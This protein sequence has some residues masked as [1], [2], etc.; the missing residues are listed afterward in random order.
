MQAN[1]LADTATAMRRTATREVWLPRTTSPPAHNAPAWRSLKPRLRW[2]PMYPPRQAMSA[3]NENTLLF[4]SPAKSNHLP[5]CPRL[6]WGWLGVHCA[7]PRSAGVGPAGASPLQHLTGCGCLSA[8]P[9]GREASSAARPHGLSRRRAAPKA[10]NTPL[11][12]SD[13]RERGGTVLAGNPATGGASTRPTTRPTPTSGS[14]PT[15]RRT[16]TSPRWLHNHT[17]A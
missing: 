14:P 9:A 17:A 12:G 5:R 16:D 15:R 4:S 13:R 10:A 8:A 1:T 11:G 3:P 6:G 7:Q 2:C